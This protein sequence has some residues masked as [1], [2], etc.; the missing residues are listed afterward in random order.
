MIRI[1][2][3]PD[4]MTVD[5]VNEYKKIF[6]EMHPYERDGEI[7][8]E[9]DGD[10]IDVYLNVTEKIPFQRIRRITGYLTGTIDRW[11]NAKRL[12]LGDRVKHES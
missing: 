3:F 10:F 1:G 12:E 2:K 6:C 11:N 8:I 4:G 9:I 5:E 7:N